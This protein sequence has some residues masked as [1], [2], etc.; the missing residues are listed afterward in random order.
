M[1]FMRRNKKNKL[2]PILGAMLL[3][4]VL[5][6]CDRDGGK[7][8]FT[9]GFEEDE[10]FRI[11]EVSCTLPE[12]MIYQT[13]MQNKYEEAF[14]EE[15]WNI[16]FENA[17]LEDN[18]K[19]IALAQIAQMKSVYLLA[20]QQ[21]VELTPEEEEKLEKAAKEY[22]ASLNETEVKTM[23]VDQDD[24]EKL[25]RQYALAQ[26]VYEQI[27]S[28]VNPE[29]SDDEAR[30]VVVEQ[31]LI[32]TYVPDSN[33]KRI[34]YSASMKADCL[35]TMETIH[36][37]LVTEGKDFTELAGKYS[38]SEEI[39]LSLQKGEAIAAI[40]NVVFNMSKDEIS[41]IIE[42]TEGYYILK[43][44][45]TLDRAQTDANKLVI[46]EQR[47]K[48]AFNREYDVFVNALARR[49]NEKLWKKVQLIHDAGVDTDDF[50]SI[51]DK[52]FNE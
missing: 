24:I 4:M 22:Y 35:E 48:D 41:D 25:Y 44:I 12:Y 49:L 46:V 8:V 30:T 6:A 19:D 21:D 2:A 27:V 13:N 3:V 1:R 29:I 26:K 10:L 11:G 50:F 36:E 14:G 17:A 39:R 51:Y 42:T 52:Y 28:Q 40:D 9:T 32:K 5:T 23:G 38:E 33:G 20:L 45:S 43:C 47:K 15:V 37:A 16:T 18:V 31:I 7:V 34:E